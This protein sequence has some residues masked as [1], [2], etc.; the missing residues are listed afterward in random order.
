MLMAIRNS[1]PE[2]I[3]SPV[4]IDCFSHEKSQLK[5]PVE[6]NP[7]SC[8]GSIAISIESDPIDYGRFSDK[9]CAAAGNRRTQKRPGR[10]AGKMDQP[11]DTETQTDFGF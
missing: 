10:P 1:L 2:N 5:K 9:I 8:L 4:E 6:V 3:L 7:F 11:I